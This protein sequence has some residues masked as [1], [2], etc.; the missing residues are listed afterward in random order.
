VV[1]FDLDRRN[2]G[3]KSFK[4]GERIIRDIGK[5]GKNTAK[6]FLPA[7]LFLLFMTP[8]DTGI[9]FV[10]APRH[11]SKQAQNQKCKKGEEDGSCSVFVGWE[12]R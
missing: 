6:D 7:T 8:F 5:N 2:K 9:V 12:A 3:Q 11:S 1:F 4:N 10:A